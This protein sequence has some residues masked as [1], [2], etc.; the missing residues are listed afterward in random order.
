MKK[1][2]VI[3]STLCVSLSFSCMRNEE[4][5]VV[6]D[7]DAIG[8]GVYTAKATRATETTT[9]ALQGSTDG[10]GIF[11][12]YTLSD[13]WAATCK[14][15]YMYNQKVTYNAA[16]SSWYYTPVKYWP[17][18]LGDKLTFFAYAPWEEPSTTYTDAAPAVGVNMVPATTTMTGAPKIT[19]RVDP[20]PVNHVDF[21]YSNRTSTRNVV[22]QTT[23]VQFQFDHAMT[24]VNFQAK[25]NKNL[26]G[27]TGTDGTT[28]VFIKDMYIVPASE[29]LWE[30]AQ[31]EFE[32][33]TWDYT[34]EN[35]KARKINPNFAVDFTSIRVFTADLGVTDY[36]P[37]M[38]LTGATSAALRIDSTTPVPMFKKTEGETPLQHY[39]FLIPPSATGVT[40]ETDVMVDVAYDIVTLDPAVKG[41]YSIAK[42]TERVSLPVGSLQMGKAYMFT[43]TIGLEN[44]EV[45]ETVEDWVENDPAELAAPSVEVNDGQNG[46]YATF[47][48]G[49]AALNA[50]KA[51]D[52]DCNY[53]V[54]YL[55]NAAVTAAQIA[56]EL[57]T[58]SK[59]SNFAVGDIIEIRI[60][61]TLTLD[62]NDIWQYSSDG[63]TFTTRSNSLNSYYFRRDVAPAGYTSTTFT[64]TNLS[65]TR[66]STII[67]TYQGGT[68]K[69]NITSLITE[70]GVEKPAGWNVTAFDVKGNPI[71]VPGWLTFS[72]VATKNMNSNGQQLD[73]WLI[74]DPQLD[75]G[76][77][78]PFW[79]VTPVGSVASPHLLVKEGGETANCY[80]VSAPGTY[81]FPCNV[82]GN[83]YI[84]PNASNFVDYT[85]NTITSAA[86]DPTGCTAEVLWQTQ[87]GAITSTAVSGNNI[88]FTTAN[89]NTLK[90][91]NAVIALK[92]SAGTIVWSWHIWITDEL[93]YDITMERGGAYNTIM[94][95]NLGYFNNTNYKYRPRRIT[96]RLTQCLSGATIDLLLSQLGYETFE[97]DYGGVHYQYGRKDP[98]PYGMDNNDPTLYRPT[99]QGGQ[100]ITSIVREYGAITGTLAATIQNPSKYYYWLLSGG[101]RPALYS[102]VNHYNLWGSAAANS[103]STVKTIYDPCPAGYMVPKA[104]VFSGSQYVSYDTY[105]FYL[106]D[107]SG[108]SHPFPIAGNRSDVG[109]G[110]LENVGSESRLMTTYGYNASTYFHFENNSF[111]TGSTSAGTGMSVR[112]MV[113]PQ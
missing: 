50:T 40:S 107:A 16:Q 75:W 83:G 84:V 80:I 39:A 60:P 72:G 28:Y 66:V 49:L 20:D 25:L 101:G 1:L 13:D 11:A 10:L 76:G 63:N 92:N 64:L 19:V 113:M 21:L 52:T 71:P 93:D 3:V 95:S 43:L 27:I 15:D 9:A 89:Q 91:G 90:K 29:K 42:T 74:C 65:G 97:G 110:G 62:N 32:N 5:G 100:E 55:N 6:K 81:S 38:I 4:V 67:P 109:T 58:A 47:A 35:V 96:V 105:Q 108:V 46:S 102:D 45:T 31:F 111:G 12:Y 88:V 2:L 103:S 104:E 70:N 17:N 87:S 94:C 69:F 44:I 37:E 54:I 98:F 99:S 56:T 57:S 30:A 26:A 61:Y 14:P 7:T 41:G 77:K 68:F 59:V 33:G 78:P 34:T 51:V 82:M 85:G 112:P 53:F 24:R 18:T 23:P 22:K 73:K 79:F 86:I 8:F 36:T 48:E 106:N